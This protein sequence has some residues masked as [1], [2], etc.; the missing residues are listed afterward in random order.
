MNLIYSMWGWPVQESRKK[1]VC[2][3]MQV[4]SCYVH[5]HTCVHACD[6]G[7][8]LLWRRKLLLYSYKHP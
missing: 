5:V 6:H 7:E 3:C 4:C 1:Y 2:V 8:W